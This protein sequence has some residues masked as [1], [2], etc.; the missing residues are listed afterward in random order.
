MTQWTDAPKDE[1]GKYGGLLDL[2]PGLIYSIL[3][4]DVKSLPV[5]LDI[6]LAG[7][8]HKYTVPAEEMIAPLRGL[9][10]SGAPAVNHQFREIAVYRDPAVERAAV[11]GRAFLSQASILPMAASFAPVETQMKLI[12]DLVQVYLFV[13][14]E[15][16]IYKM[17]PLNKGE[18]IDNAVSSGTCPAGSGGGV[19]GGTYITIGALAAVILLLLIAVLVLGVQ[20][21][22]HRKDLATVTE[23]MTA[24]D[25]YPP[26]SAAPPPPFITLKPPTPPET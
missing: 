13:D 15:K 6:T 26:P 22:K 14:Y 4:S 16:N 25:A 8:N 18:T 1:N 19:W 23:R 3:N 5:T 9:D 11:L 12:L 20:S 21:W 24:L 2:E 10:D 17:G 7:S